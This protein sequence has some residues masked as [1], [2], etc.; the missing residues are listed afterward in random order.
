MHAFIGS[1]SQ[2]LSVSSIAKSSNSQP[3]YSSKVVRGADQIFDPM[4]FIPYPVI[5]PEIERTDFR[6]T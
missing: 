5:T 3:Q 4:R 6:S 1:C 2:N